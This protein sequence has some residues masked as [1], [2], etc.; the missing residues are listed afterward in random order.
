VPPRLAFQE[1]ELHLRD[2][3]EIS[4]GAATSKRNAFLQIAQDGLIGEG[5]A[6]FH[7][8]FGESPAT[9]HADLTRATAGLTSIELNQ[10]DALPFTGASRTALEMALLD[11]QAKRANLP[12]HRFL[13][14]PASLHPILT[15]FSIGID[16]PERMHEKALAA[17]DFHSVKIKLGTPADRERFEAVRSATTAPIR[18][19][20]NGGWETREQALEM[21]EWLADNRGVELIEQPLPAGRL[22]DTAWLTA[23]SPLPIIL[24]EDA[25]TT[26]DIP[27]LAGKCHGINIKLMKTG[28]LLEAVAM[29]NVARHHDLKIMLGCM[30]ESSLAIGAALHLAPLADW[31]DLDGHLL[32]ANDPY[33][34]ITLHHGHLLPPAGPG[35]GVHRHLPS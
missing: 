20:A 23:R 5:E 10:L 12:L 17:A 26:A 3:W 13:G 31:I 34:G 19:D 8:H 6:A 21:I 7:G 9:V 29:A 27:A 14:L 32:I 28:G 2:P 18:I 16:T 1:Y 35:I 24:D 33:Q 4:R 22:N 15:S 30:I 25:R 11:W